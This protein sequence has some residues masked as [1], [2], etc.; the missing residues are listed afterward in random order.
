MDFAV[1]LQV[2]GNLQADV[3]EQDTVN[4]SEVNVEYLDEAKQECLEFPG[5]KD[6]TYLQ[7]AQPTITLGNFLER[8]IDAFTFEWTSGGLAPLVIKPWELFFDNPAVQ[9]KIANFSYINCRLHVEIKVNSTPFN[10]GSVLF[11]FYPLPKFSPNTLGVSNALDKVFKS[12]RPHVWIS[13]EM[14]MGAE[15]ILP[16]FYHKNFLRISSRLEMQDMG[17]FDILEYVQLQAANGPVNSPV[18]VQV[19]IN[20]VD[21]MLTGGTVAGVLQA[22]QDEYSVEPIC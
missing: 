8:P 17:E 1:S 14:N 21:V 11:F 6:S 4:H 9:N 10:Y 13:P 3:T 5:L 7:D 19:L 22:E 15:M 2:L 20:A 12:Q 18:Q 16:F